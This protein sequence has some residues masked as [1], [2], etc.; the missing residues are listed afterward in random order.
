MKTY[1]N[2]TKCIIVIFILAGLTLPGPLLSQQSDLFSKVNANDL[3]G[4]KTLVAAGADL[5]QREEFYN[6]TPLMWALNSN[7]IDMAVLLINEGADVNLKASNGATALLLAAGRSY[8]VTELLLSKGADIH[9][10]SDNGSGVITNCTMGIIKAWVKT[11][12]AE[13]LLSKGA[14]IDEVNTTE[15]YGGYTPL[16]WAVDDNNEALVKFFCDHGANVNATAKNKKT[17]LSIASEAGYE[18]IAKLLKTKG[19]V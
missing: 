9:A 13:L 1:L 11:D 6:M 4:V 17:P 19:A 7:M 16:F 2:S 5:N 15:Y 10:R 14:E 12:L 8:E 18:S 3:E